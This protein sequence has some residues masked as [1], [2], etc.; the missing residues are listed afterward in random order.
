MNEYDVVVVG[1]GPAGLGA[2]CSAA[3]QGASVAL[4]DALDRIGGNAV[5]STGY[6]AF[7]DVEH[8]RAAGIADSPEC[9]LA[10]AAAQFELHR[11]KAGMIWDA[12]LTELF[13]RESPETYRRLVELGIEFT[14]LIPR[15]QQN[16]V[17]RLLAVADPARLGA[18]HE[19]RLA[20]LGVDVLLETR[21]ERLLVEAGRVV[22]VRIAEGAELR[23]RRGVVLAC[24][25]YQGNPELRRRHQPA[26]DISEH[27]VGVSSCR[28]AGHVLGASVGG[29]LINMGYIQPM[30]LVPS[31]LVEDAVAVNTAGRRFHDEAG[32]YGDRVDAL[33]DQP[34]EQA[35]YVVDG[36]TLG[37]H[38]DLV[39]RMP[40]AAVVRDTLPELAA[41]IGA[42]PVGLVDAV[43]EWN[44][45]LAGTGTRDPAFGRVVLPEAR[46]PLAE[47]PFAATAMVRG[48]SFT[49]GGL[50]VT[51]D[52]QVVTVLG[53][54]VPGL[55]AAGDTIGGMNVVSSVGGLHITGGLTLGRIAGRSAACGADAVP[56][57]VPP[58]G[59]GVLRSS[60][61]RMP[62]VD[63]R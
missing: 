51:L 47:P 58:A 18:V 42:D 41:A 32:P 37:R 62:L 31:L 7:V 61:L 39:E 26:K 29:D 21:V 55:F 59:G 2:A 48:I 63:I 27:I 11:D 34:G 60:A 36:A 44:T 3:E 24:G 45:F 40:E 50:A 9:F 13:A 1:A 15:P 46:R 25:G 28:G 33:A 22:G 8:Q 53:D 35:W 6:L 19:P 23:A 17:D 16:S 10:D 54:V 14:R 43:G 4:V 56:H 38:A 20:E 30:V 52:M 49:W 5:L 12:A 57:L